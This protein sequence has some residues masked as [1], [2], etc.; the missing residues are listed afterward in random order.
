MQNEAWVDEKNAL[1][2]FTRFQT[3]DITAQG[4]TISDR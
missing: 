2:P 4:K 3:A 1:C